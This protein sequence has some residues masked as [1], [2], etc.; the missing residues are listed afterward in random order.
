VVA[1]LGAAAVVVP[2]LTSAGD[3][4]YASW[5]PQPVPLAP[6]ESAAAAEACLAAVHRQAAPPV[7]PVLAERRGGWTYV[8]LRP[9]EDVS[10]SCLMPTDEI[11]R[12]PAADHRRWFWS[13]D[14]EVPGPVRDPEGI[15]VDSA[16]TGTTEEGLFSYSEGAVGDD[17]VDVTVTTPRGVTVTAS[18]A[19]GRYAA[20]W[21]AGQNRLR[22]PEISRAPEIDVTLADGT[23]Y[24][25][26]R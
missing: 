3:K 14:E 24:R 18:V 26:P 11:G 23:T 21:P 20:W 7:T 2:V 25:M 9:A 6:I 19:N 22:S 15:R 1:V 8:L 13:D 16:A 12:S 5:S 10:T 17:V 4:A